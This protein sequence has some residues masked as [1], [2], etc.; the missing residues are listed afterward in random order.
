[1][2]LGFYRLKKAY[3][4]TNGSL[5]GD[6]IKKLSIGDGK[7]HLWDK[8]KSALTQDVFK[9]L[10]GQR[11][12]LGKTH[13][14]LPPASV[15]EMDLDPIEDRVEVIA[16]LIRKY[17]RLPQ[18]RELAISIIARKCGDRWC[19]P[20]KH[21]QK[22]IKEIFDFVRANVRYVRDHPDVDQFSGP[23]RTL[24]Q[25]GGDCDDASLV[26][27]S[28]LMAVGHRVKLRVVQADN[29]PTWNHIYVLAN[30]DGASKAWTPLDASVNAQA[31]WEVPGAAQCAKSKKPSGRV[32]KVKD[33]DV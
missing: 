13:K 12:A 17:S 15:K 20:E 10:S 1:M 27:G 19:V 30:V 22:E 28:L 7:S 8:D 29:A 9:R 33:F 25:G 6:A 23:D 4:G 11:A 31:G 26:L 24:M 18:I 32:Q 2:L 14:E 3:L 5:L 16:N 21:W